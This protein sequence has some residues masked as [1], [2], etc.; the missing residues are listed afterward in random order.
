MKIVKELGFYFF[1]LFLFWVLLFDFQRVLFSVHN[2]GKFNDFN[3]S[4]WFLSF[5]YSIP[6][7]LSTA[8]FLSI[9]PLLFILVYIIYPSKV[10]YRIFTYLIIIEALTCSFIQSGEI[11]AY[12]EW[13]HKL[14]PR[15]FTHL[16]NPN[17]VFRTADYLMTFFFFFY[18]LL[19]MLFAWKIIFFFFKRKDIIIPEKI[20]FRVLKGVISFIFVGGFSFLL[21]RG[22][23]QQ[24][25]I[26]INS[27]SFSKSHIINDL[28]TNSTYYFANSYLI[29]NR[30]DID[31]L[32]PVVEPTFANSIVKNLYNYNHDYD[33]KIFTIKYPNIVL[34]ILESWAAEAVGCLSET[35][36]ATSNFDLLS[37]EGLLFTNIYST[38]ST[39]EIGNISIFS[40][41]PSIPQISFSSQ[42]E[43]HRKLRAL[44]QDFQ[45]LG[46]SSG[47]IFSGDLKYGNIEGYFLDHGFE[48]VIDERSFPSQLDRGKLNYYDESLYNLFFERINQSNEPFFQCAFTGSTHSPYDHPKDKNF[49]WKGIESNFMNSLIYADRCIGDFMKKCKEKSWYDNTVFVFVADHGHATPNFQSPHETEFYRIPLLF[50]GKPLKE[51]FR[52]KKINK[53]G[54]QLDIARTLMNQIDD[55]N[56]FYTWSKDLLNPNVS[57]FA[58]HTVIGG[59]GWVT[60]KGSMIY[61]LQSQKIINSTFPKEKEEEEINK[62]KAF[63]HKIYK[64]YKEL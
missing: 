46:Y 33:S 26:N 5:I 52:G 1:K 43:K 17:E 57:Q 12:V 38:G 53:I 59:Y 24:I 61:S 35:K 58:F 48:D 63:L 49:N 32:I 18:T 50:W 28:C 14:T 25:P 16:S 6:L 36:G 37:E 42:P 64:Y 27:S 4:D 56:S 11:N 47:Y 39:S 44:N 3:Y 62:G 45:E 9:L 51:E 21:A 2:W 40:G 29:Y 54:S 8:S 31:N 20:F 19:Q 60:E 22:G 55:K 13:N 41:V 30:S 23:T 7:D 15:V 10:T 34:V